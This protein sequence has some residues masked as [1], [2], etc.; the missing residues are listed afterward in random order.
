MKVTEIL[1]EQHTQIRTVLKRITSGHDARERPQ[2]V[3]RLIAELQIHGRLEELI[4]YPALRELDTKKA[5][6]QVLESVEEHDIF[7]FVVAQLPFMDFESERFLARVRVLQ[8]LV[9]EHVVEE[10]DQLFKQAERL[11]QEEL[12]RLG[13]EMLIRIEEVQ[14]VTEVVARVAEITARLEKWGGRWLDYSI[15]LPRRLAST[16]AP[17][18][19]LG[20]DQRSMWVAAL[21]AATPRWIVDGAYELVVRPAALRNGR[22]GNGRISVETAGLQPELAA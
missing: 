7:D 21:A 18:R 13:A 1:R 17:S 3:D 19:I 22:A 15:G 20:F 9:E 14:R 12:D 8:S 6:E 5:E 2:L 10:E 11:G 16:L 4:F